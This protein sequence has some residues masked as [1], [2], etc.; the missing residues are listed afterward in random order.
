MTIRRGL[1]GG[2]KGVSNGSGE[3]VREC[4]NMF[5]RLRSFKLGIESERCGGSGVSGGVGEGADARL[6][7][8]ADSTS[9]VCPT[10]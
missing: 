10:W 1:R 2:D 3:G 7:T 6:M 8:R 5:E 9:K 4:A